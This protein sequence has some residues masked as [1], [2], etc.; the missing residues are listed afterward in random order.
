LE[1]KICDVT[2]K[3]PRFGRSNKPLDLFTRVDLSHKYTLYRQGW[4]FNLKPQKLIGPIHVLPLYV[5]PTINKYY[6]P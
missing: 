1:C 2:Q 6:V 5:P 3:T 4:D